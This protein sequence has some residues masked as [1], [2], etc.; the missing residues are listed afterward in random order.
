M[1]D[2]GI[3]GGTFDPIHIAHLVIA[4]NAAEQFNLDKIL[5][6]TGGNP[7]HKEGRTVTD[8][9]L[10]HEM[11]KR[12]I[13]TNDKFE[14]CD[15]EILKEEFSYTAETLEY[16]CSNNP[17]NRYFLIIGQDS[18][19]YLEKWYKPEVIVNLSTVLVYC[20]GDEDISAEMSRIKGFFDADIR[21]I[22]SPRIDISATD[23]RDKIKKGK[24]VKYFV[25][26]PVL[27]FIYENNLYK[28]DK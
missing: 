26:E 3:M 19:A 9:I 16:L 6:M 13:F 18:L 25:P 5:F 15:Y 11:V 8:A 4:E 21:I 22:N 23:I 2:I 17:E 10:R 27:S 1:A 20:R 28:G 24:T 14:A 7:P 12:A